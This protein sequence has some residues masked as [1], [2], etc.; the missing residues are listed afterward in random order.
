MVNIYSFGWLIL[1]LAPEL[2]FS[3]YGFTLKD[4]DRKFF[5]GAGILPY[6]ADQVKEMTLKEIYEKYLHWICLSFRTLTKSLYI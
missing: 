2:H 3:Y 4:L 6:F 1:Q 5:L